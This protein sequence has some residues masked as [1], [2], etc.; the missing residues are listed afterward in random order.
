MQH[1]EPPSP[2]PFKEEYKTNNSWIF[3][4]GSTLTGVGGAGAP[5][6]APAGRI[7]S[8]W[9]QHTIPLAT[10][11]GPETVGH[12]SRPDKMQPQDFCQKYSKA[13]TLIPPG[14]AGVSLGLPSHCH[15]G[16]SCLSTMTRRRQR[17][18]GDREGQTPGHVVGTSGSIHSWNHNTPD[19]SVT[20]VNVVPLLLIQFELGFY[21]LG[22]EE[23]WLTFFPSFRSWSVK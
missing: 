4:C 5:P 1:Q 7:R 17:D 19:F 16:R 10:R 22:S 2:I 23:P 3:F 6:R 8:D 13:D 18:S 15:S 14:M 11:I 12:T 21:H 20:F 9:V